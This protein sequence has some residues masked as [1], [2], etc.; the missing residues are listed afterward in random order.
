MVPKIATPNAPPTE[1]KNVA[2]EVATPMSCG[3]TSF[4]TTR[5]EHLHDEPDADPDDEHVD[6]GE[7][8][9]GPDLQPREQVHADDQDRG[10]RDRERPCS[11][12]CA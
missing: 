7:P 9:G 8:G 10:A 12:Q 3:R 6:G 1:R 11:A 2:V 5:I 4:W